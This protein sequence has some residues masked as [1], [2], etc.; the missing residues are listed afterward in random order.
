MKKLLI[1]VLLGMFIFGL[2]GGVN[3]ACTDNC[4]GSVSLIKDLG[5]LNSDV[6]LNLIGGTHGVDDYVKVYYNNVLQGGACAAA[7]RCFTEGSVVGSVSGF[8]QTFSDLG[9]NSIELKL[10][11]SGY[12]HTRMPGSITS[13]GLSLYTIYDSSDHTGF[14]FLENS[15]CEGF[16]GI[17]C[18]RLSGEDY[19]IRG[20]SPGYPADQTNSITFSYCLAGT[21][22]VAQCGNGIDEDCSGADLACSVCTPDCLAEAAAT[23]CGQDVL[24]DGC[25]GPCAGFVGENSSS[26]NPSFSCSP[27]GT[28]V[29]VGEAYWVDMLGNNI[30]IAQ[31]GDTVQMAAA[32]VNVSGVEA[33]FTIEI[34]ASF[35][36]YNPITWFGSGEIK[37][38]ISEHYTINHTDDHRFT[39]DISELGILK[40]SEKL[41]IEDPDDYIPTLE[42]IT[43]S[44][45]DM[46]NVGEDLEIKINSTDID[47]LINGTVAFNGTIIENLTNGLNTFYHR[48]T[49]AGEITLTATLYSR[50][51]TYSN[52]TNIIVK[53]E[54][55]VGKFAAACIDY[56]APEEYFTN[57][58]VRFSAESTSGVICD[59]T[60]CDILPL[61][62]SSLRYNWTFPTTPVA[63]R[64]IRGNESMDSNMTVPPYL[65]YVSFDSSG[66]HPAKLDVQVI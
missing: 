4:Q 53:N 59:G 61:N 37:T 7:D 42:I 40:E 52:S 23:A 65:F 32:G 63:N 64:F 30:S 45:G 41:S 26:C 20:I 66:R 12:G 60:S 50:G 2:I 21:E 6:N 44:C 14:W 34:G 19:G 56:P 1:L 62:S 27:L 9:V 55:A 33:N 3:A 47:D 39:V 24:D 46:A 29:E 57:S 10:V 35:V 25:G 5:N 13:G 18:Y 31:M 48:P 8:S 58:T 51:I 49:A 15:I 17:V 54:S 38:S 16:S 11:D 36:W 43:P 28:C 22:G